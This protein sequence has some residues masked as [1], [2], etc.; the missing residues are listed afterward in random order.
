MSKLGLFILFFSLQSFA[1][2]DLKGTDG[3]LTSIFDGPAAV[4]LGGAGL[5]AKSPNESGQVNP[6]TLPLLDGSHF[7]FIY[8]AESVGPRAGSNKYHLI[9]TEATDEVIFPGSLSLSKVGVFKDGRDLSLQ[10]LHG[11]VGFDISDFVSVGL[12]IK[13]MTLDGQNRPQSN[14]FNSTLGVLVSPHRSLG[15]ALVF[16]DFIDSNQIPSI[17]TLG[18]GSQYIFDRIL[19]VR[20][21][22]ILPQENNPNRKLILK[23]GLES[24][25]LGKDFNFRLGYRSDDFRAQRYFATGLGWQGPKLGLNYGYERNV[26][27]EDYRH[28]IDMLLQF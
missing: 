8:G 25:F 20:A 26:L 7:G 13:Y 3:T 4:A 15:F 6:A 21:D 19:R 24:L 1:F 14:A 11:A 9:I 27:S 12:A 18:F 16:D 28:I 5:A 23:A 10:Q 22:A 17:S 2:I